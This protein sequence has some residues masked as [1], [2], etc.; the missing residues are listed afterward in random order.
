[1]RARSALPTAARGSLVERLR[2]GQWPRLEDALCLLAAASALSKPGTNIALALCVVLFARDWVGGRRRP[3]ATPLDG[4]ILAWILT[5]LLS[6]V[7]S[8]DPLR[9]FRDLRNLGHW[10][11]Y[12]LIVWG[13][14][15]GASLRRLQNVWLAAGVVSA[16]QALAQAGLGFDL[17]GRG[18]GRATGFFGGHLE[19][20]HYMVVL[21]GLATARRAEAASKRE[22]H[23]LLAVIAIL[24]AALVVSNGRGPW[25]AFVAM[26][27]AW[28]VVQRR[29]RALSA[30]ALVAALQFAVLSHRPAGLEAFYR[31]YVTFEVEGPSPVP[32]AQVASNVWRLT[33]WRE[34]LRLYSLRPLT[35]TGV[36]TTGELSRDFH[37]PF[38]GFGVAHLHSNYFE[39]LMTRGFFGLAAFFLLLFVSTRVFVS[40][41]SAQASGEA[42]A[43]LFAALA[44][45]VAH[46]IHGLTQFTIGS[47]W[48]QVGFY[49]AIGLGVGALGQKREDAAAAATAGLRVTAAGSAWAIVTVAVGLLVAPVFLRHPAVVETL[50][51]LA[52]LDFSARSALGWREPIGSALAAAFV[53]IVVAAFVLL[54]LVPGQEETGIHVIAAGS[55]PFAISYISLWLATALRRI[56]SQH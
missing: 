4:V 9:S 35:G 43:A 37:T 10:L 6:G 5:E 26:S 21:I 39:L 45:A 49:V 15:G 47:S 56:P 54:V 2:S 20:G 55:A 53:F 11:V 3:L 23:I 28:A 24:G 42:R 38:Q 29:A 52:L 40:A 46:L 16:T 27:V 17:L 30:L 50:A 1:M 44:A 8:I 48:I 33:M 13:L 25:L 7:T 36:E 12:Y 34:G 32:G 22:R 31:S 14:S 51:V 19:L 18:G 41:L